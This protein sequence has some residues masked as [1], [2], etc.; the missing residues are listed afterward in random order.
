MTMSFLILAQLWAVYGMYSP[1]LL[2]S[3]CSLTVNDSIA[4]LNR[5]I[6]RGAEK[7]S[8][9]LSTPISQHLSLD[10]HPGLWILET[11]W[12]L[13]TSYS[14]IKALCCWEEGIWGRQRFGFRV[15]NNK[16]QSRKCY[17]NAHQAH[18][19]H[20]SNG[21]QCICIKDHCSKAWS[22]YILQTWII[23]SP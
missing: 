20:H 16:S 8:A 18:S 19:L 13:L 12:S 10:I 11:T 14:A 9:C 4:P 5:W 1:T 15:P 22:Y 23:H 17:W 21:W 3:S 6:N 7:K 2:S